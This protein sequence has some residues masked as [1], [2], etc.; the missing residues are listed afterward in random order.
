[1][2]VLGPGALVVAADDGPPRTPRADRPTQ[3]VLRPTEFPELAP[4]VAPVP[5]AK[6]AIVLVSGIN[7]HPQD[8]TFDPLI[9][10]LFGDPRYEIYRFG[11]DPAYPY[12]TLGDLDANARNL[13]DEVRA[14]GATHPAVHIVAHSMGGAVADRAFSSGLAASDGVAT[15]VAL[16]SPHNGSSTLAASTGVLAAAG[17]SA[18]EV[19]A[20]FS[21][22]LD[23]GSDAA[24]GL[25]HT[26]PVPPPAGVVR[27]DL[28]MSTDWTVTARDA[29]DPGIESRT[30]A[31]SDLGGYVD[32]HG[33]VI[34]DPQAL[35]L[36]TSTIEQRSIPADPRSAGLKT[37][38]D[39]QSR[40]AGT[41]ALL[42]ALVGLAVG[43]CICVGLLCVP[44]LRL[45]TRPLAQMQLRAV[46][47]T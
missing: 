39:R 34:R 14:L 38:A 28:R 22:K 35:R 16:A 21:P 8:P 1:M 20:V 7:S 19:R 31:P 15:Y 3:T 33:A 40:A 17:D 13:R 41:L 45:L 32:G 26:R 25:A 23:P 18:L 44:A 5:S 47:R 29:T 11:A 2:A 9:A 12:D 42:I 30:L 24:R 10:K 4:A 36:I 37:A 27:L 6:D 43:G 46:R